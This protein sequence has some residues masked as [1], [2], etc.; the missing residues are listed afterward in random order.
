VAQDGMSNHVRSLFGSM[1]S[2]Y[3]RTDASEN[4]IIAAGSDSALECTLTQPSHIELVHHE[5]IGIAVNISERYL[6]KYLLGRST[7]YATSLQSRLEQGPKTQPLPCVAE[8]RA[9]CRT[10]SANLPQISLPRL[11]VRQS[12][13]ERTRF[14]HSYRTTPSTSPCHH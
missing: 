4:I 13:P 2:H 3:T 9:D 12:L 11:S 10:V 1:R 6:L 7:T 8:Q 5:M 14:D